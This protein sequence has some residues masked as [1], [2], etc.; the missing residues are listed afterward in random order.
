[1][2]ISEKSLENR[3]KLGKR[4]NVMLCTTILATPPLRN[5]LVQHTLPLTELKFRRS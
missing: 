2:P 5:Y 3:E 1:M 4:I